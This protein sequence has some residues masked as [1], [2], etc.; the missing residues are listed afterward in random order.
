MRLEKALIG[1]LPLQ[2]QLSAA[3]ELKQ[4]ELELLKKENELLHKELFLRE[5]EDRLRKEEE[6]RSLFEAVDA[7]YLDQNKFVM[8]LKSKIRKVAPPP[9]YPAV[10]IPTR[11]PI[12]LCHGN[13]LLI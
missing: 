12:V 4:K 13:F 10:P 7:G 5:W 1:E 2:Y 6:S 11:Y 3:D 8:R 9:P